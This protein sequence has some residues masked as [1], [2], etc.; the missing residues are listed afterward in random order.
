[1]LRN[2]DF[3]Y[4]SKVFF[5]VAQKY[6]I[7]I[8]MYLYFARSFRSDLFLVFFRPEK[9]KKN[10]NN[11]LKCKNVLLFKNKVEINNLFL[12]GYRQAVHRTINYAW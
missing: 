5:F 6:S 7:Y 3:N 9:K 12:R 11:K 2:S 1:M 10:R 4:L 8:Y